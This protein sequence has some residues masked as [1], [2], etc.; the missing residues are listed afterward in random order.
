MRRCNRFQSSCGGHRYFGRNSEKKLQHTPNL[1]PRSRRDLFVLTLGASG[2]ATYLWLSN[3]VEQD[4]QIAVDSLLSRSKEGMASDLEVVRDMS[5][6]LPPPVKRYLDEVLP[7]QANSR[8]HKLSA[9][10][11]SGEFLAA[12]KWYPFEASLRIKGSFGDPCFVWNA[13]T[14]IYGMPQQILQTL[15]GGRGSI[16]TKAWGKIPTVQIQE[17]EP[18]ILFWLA[19]LPLCPQALIQNQLEHQSLEWIEYDFHT[20]RARLITYPDREEYNLEFQF[21]KNSNV[22]LSI[23]VTADCI[24]EP[25]K[26]TYRDYMRFRDDLLAP[27][28]IEIGKGTGPRFRYHMTLINRSMQ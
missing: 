24:E 3:D 4:L 25:W 1:S 10:K 7:V 14:T 2:A 27:S 13:N 18:F 12:Q 21:D 19:M 15:V 16:T 5:E 17:E 11:Q 22:L 23:A 20:A 26:V 6:E 9:A 8:R 28:R